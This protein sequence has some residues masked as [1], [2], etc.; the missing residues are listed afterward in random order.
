MGIIVYWFVEASVSLQVVNN[1]II[2]VDCVTTSCVVG[3]H[4]EDIRG[5]TQ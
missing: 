3:Y 5:H 1:Y 4:A 2:T